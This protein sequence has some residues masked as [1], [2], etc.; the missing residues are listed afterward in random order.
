MPPSPK[1]PKP[2]DAA[3]LRERLDALY[4]HYND[5]R[6]VHPDPLETVLPFEDPADQEIAGLVASALA[7]GGVKQI[8]R[9]IGAVF[10]AMGP[11][12]AFIDGA[13]AKGMASRFAGFRHRYVTDAE[14]IALLLGVKRVR[15]RH[16]SLEACYMQGAVAGDPLT[17]FV[18]ALASTDGAANYLLPDPE[19]G[20]ACKRLHLYLRWMVRRDAVDPGPWRSASPSLLIVPIDTHM[21]RIAR[22]LGW[23]QRAQADGTTAREVTNA[24]RT[25][26]PE[27]PVRFD[28]SLTRIGIR[29]DFTVDDFLRGDF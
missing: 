16:G 11:P 5:R 12:R 17:G 26:C 7:F 2:R 6:W 20:S 18:R 23:T 27:D 29:G 9:S 4:R 19:K 3:L 13:T 1:R 8:L 10:D 14:L 24:C 22:C 25:L 21:H 15:E 28:F